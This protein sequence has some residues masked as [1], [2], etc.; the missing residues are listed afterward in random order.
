MSK[1][2][3]INRQKVILGV[4]YSFKHGGLGGGSPRFTDLEHGGLGLPQLVEGGFPRGHLDDGA[5][6]GPD[7]GRGA[8]AP[9]T[10]IDDLWSHVLEGAWT[11]NQDENWL[12][13]LDLGALALNLNLN[14]YFY[15]L[16]A[17]K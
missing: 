14:H 9:R 16:T 11:H 3:V 6:Q 10:L 12:T 7:V 4:N 5:P 2:W 8:V 1:A 13:H 17:E 15:H